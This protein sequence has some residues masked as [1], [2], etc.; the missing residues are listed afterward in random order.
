MRGPSPRASRALSRFSLGTCLLALAGCALDKSGQPARTLFSAVA[1]QSYQSSVYVVARQRCAGCHTSTQS[2]YFASRDLREA[3][4]QAKLFTNFND[5]GA[6]VLVERSS[7]SHCGSNC[8]GNPAEMSN[9]IRRWWDGGESEASQGLAGKIVLEPLPIPANVPV[10]GNTFLELTWSLENAIGEPGATFKFSARW[11]DDSKSTLILTKPRVTAQRTLYYRS[12]DVLVNSRLAQTSG[13]FKGLEGTINGGQ[14]PVLSTTQ[15]IVIAGE[16]ATLSPVFDALHET[17]ALSCSA[18]AEFLASA[19]P[20]L[21]NR[22]FGCHASTS[23]NAT[24]VLARSRLDMLTNDETLCDRALQRTN[25]RTSSLSPLVRNPR[26]G[27]NGHPLNPNGTN[28]AD[29]DALLLWI[30]AEAAA[31][32]L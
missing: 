8:S 18:R 26:T 19:R 31:L 16:G 11:T 13:S 28:A 24:V 14:A 23:T 7:D 3:Y 17:L 10:G 27:A 22:C 9:A 2:P 21:A 32:G 29:E 1:M 25:L 6:S 30:E 5:Y 12:I 15:M 4:I 20:V